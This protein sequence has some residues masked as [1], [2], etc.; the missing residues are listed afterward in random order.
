V[1]KNICHEYVQYYL[2]LFSYTRATS[3]CVCAHLLDKFFFKCALCWKFYWLSWL[4]SQGK[5]CFHTFDR[6]DGIWAYDF[7]YKLNLLI[8]MVD[9]S[10][11]ILLYL[12]GFD[13]MIFSWVDNLI[14]NY[15][16]HA[17]YPSRRFCSILI[18]LPFFI[19]FQL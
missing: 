18:F 5:S 15:K 12:M 9:G 17:T 13:L 8:S 7:Q 4:T 3:Y 6:F 19:K 1:G 11:K 2:Q 14:Y 10:S 16:Y